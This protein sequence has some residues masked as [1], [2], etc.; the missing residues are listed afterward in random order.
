MSIDDEHAIRGL[1]ETYARGAD[2]RQPAL[3]ASVFA[4]DGVLQIYSGDPEH[5][6]TLD[7]E[8]RGR[9]E[10][11]TAMAGLARYRVTFHGL[12]QSTIDVAADSTSATSETYCVAHHLSD[13]DNGSVTDRVM[14]IRYRD[15]WTNTP[16]GWAL[17]RRRLAVDWI[18]ERT[19]THPVD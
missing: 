1:I 19:V 12:Q 5:E 13:L 6:G 17:Q 8:R 16:D 10:I 18:D 9:A 7:R 15:D 3:T 4:D 2:R 11:E 14:F